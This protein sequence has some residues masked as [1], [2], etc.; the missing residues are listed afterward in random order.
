MGPL[1][2]FIPIT[3]GEEVISEE[4]IG[5]L[6]QPEIDAGGRGVQVPDRRAAPGNPR[7]AELEEETNTETQTS[8]DA[9]EEDEPEVAPLWLRAYDQ[10]KKKRGLV[11]KAGHAYM[12]YRK[13]KLG[14]RLATALYSLG[15]VGWGIIIGIIIFLAL[16]SAFG[17]GDGEIKKNAAQNQAAETLT[18]RKEKINPPE[19]RANIGDI[20]TFNIIVTDI[21]S[22]QEITIIDKIPDGV[23]LVESDITST[24]NTNRVFDPAAKTLTWKASENLPPNSL[25]TPNFT[26]TVT[27]KVTGNNVYLVTWAEA[28]VVRGGGGAFGGQNIPP[29]NDDCHG[30]YRSYMNMLTTVNKSNYGDPNCQLAK[31]DPN[32]RW[33]IDKDTIFSFMWESQ[34]GPKLQRTE[35]EGVFVCIMPKECGATYNVNAFNPKSTSTSRGTPGAFGCF[36]MNATGFS[37]TNQPE[38]TGDVVWQ[39]QIHNANAWRNKYNGGRWRNYWPTSYSGCLEKFGL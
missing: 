14:L 1:T 37:N 2:R 12:D 15:P 31:Q 7:S 36:Q 13:I 38:D 10:Y 24:W 4:E 6:E 34:D 21:R 26:I 33:F 8:Q 3:V 16:F 27:Y 30:L 20:V 17:W 22:A 23:S 29:S 32:G 28:N 9:P 18:I 35:A 19:L 5:F 25:N 39:L 11:R